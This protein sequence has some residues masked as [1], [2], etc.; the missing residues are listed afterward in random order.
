MHD[1]LVKIFEYLTKLGNEKEV[2]SCASRIASGT[3]TVQKEKKVIL[4]N[5]AWK[6]FSQI[7]TV[8]QG[9]HSENIFQKA[10]REFKKSQVQKN[11]TAMTLAGTW[12]FLHG[13]DLASALPVGFMNQDKFLTWCVN[14]RRR[15]HTRF[16][17]LLQVHDVEEGIIKLEDLQSHYS[18]VSKDGKVHF[19]YDNGEDDMVTAQA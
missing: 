15:F 9:E 11:S 14:R 18:V 10:G 17:S 6:F 4:W 19:I 16:E 13:V 3:L 12:L 7:P 1:T 5:P 8:W 2:W